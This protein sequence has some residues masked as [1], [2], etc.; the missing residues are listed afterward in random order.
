[1][2]TGFIVGFRLFFTF[3]LILQIEVN[4]ILLECFGIILGFLIEILRFFC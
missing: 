1:M 3:C 2:S 4:G